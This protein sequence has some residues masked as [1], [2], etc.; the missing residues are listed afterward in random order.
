MLARVYK[1]CVGY[2]LLCKVGFHTKVEAH[3]YRAEHPWDSNKN[4]KLV[5]ARVVVLGN[6]GRYYGLEQEASQ[7]RRAKEDFLWHHLI[8]IWHRLDA[9]NTQKI[10]N[11]PHQFPSPIPKYSPES[12]KNHHLLFLEEQ[13]PRPV[14][15]PN[16]NTH[17]HNSTINSK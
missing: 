2:L 14:C 1:S 15:L 4:E 7:R 8:L 3:S 11:P 13:I 6:Q 5:F 16:L 9:Y 17:N 10:N 12:S